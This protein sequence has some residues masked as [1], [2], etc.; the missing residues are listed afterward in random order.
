MARD[1][2]Q[3]LSDEKL[4]ELD[5]FTAELLRQFCGNFLN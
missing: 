4:D 5:E 3:I 1:F 2:A